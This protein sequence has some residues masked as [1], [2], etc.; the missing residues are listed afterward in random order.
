MNQRCCEDRL[1]GGGPTDSGIRAGL[2]GGCRCRFCRGRRGVA[3][4]SG[5]GYRTPRCQWDS[6]QSATRTRPE[7][8]SRIGPYDITFGK[9]KLTSLVLWLLKI[10][11]GRPVDSRSVRPPINAGRW[12]RTELAGLIHCWR[13]RC[14]NTDDKKKGKKWNRDGTVSCSNHFRR[15]CINRNRS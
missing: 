14:P 10:Q 15:N 5:G 3:R 9:E 7:F 8:A 4:G 12:W 13:G 11:P 6:H 1:R 2:V